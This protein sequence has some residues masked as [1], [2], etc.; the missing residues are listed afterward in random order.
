MHAFDGSPGAHANAKVSERLHARIQP[1]TLP[2]ELQRRCR[3]LRKASTTRARSHFIF[4]EDCANVTNSQRLVWKQRAEQRD[5]NPRQLL[6]VWHAGIGQRRPPCISIFGAAGILSRL[7]AI[8]FI[9]PCRSGWRDIAERRSRERATPASI[10][11]G[12]RSPGTPA[13]SEGA[14]IRVHD[15]LTPGRESLC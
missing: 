5:R 2:P 13:G 14:T 9:P 4:G 1:R 6:I 8:R 7:R 3:Q 12:A 10:G 11:R 15:R